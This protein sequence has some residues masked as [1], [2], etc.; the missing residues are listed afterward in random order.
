LKRKCVFRKG[1]SP[2]YRY[3]WKRFL[4]FEFIVFSLQNYGQLVTW[5]TMESSVQFAGQKRGAEHCTSDI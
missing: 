3:R 1:E 4:T 5:T 2:V